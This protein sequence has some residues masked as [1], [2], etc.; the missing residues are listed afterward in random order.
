MKFYSVWLI[1]LTMLLATANASAA[2]VNFNGGAVSTCTLSGNTYSC[3]GMPLGDN[4]IAVIASGYTVVLSSGF[5][6]GWA[7]GLSMSGSAALQTTSGNPI[8]LT[9]SNNISVSGGTLTAGGTFTLGSNP[10]TITANVFAAAVST[11]GSAA[12]I[13]GNVTAGSADFGSH[14]T[15]SG[16]VNVGTISTNADVSMGSLTATGSISLGSKNTVTGAVIGASISTNSQ[17]TMGSLT[18]SG[19]ADLASQN[20]VNGPVSANVLT[21]NSNVTLNGDINATSSF[22][23][24][25]GS[26]LTGNV[27]SPTV[28]LNPSNVTVQGNI[29]ASNTLDIGSG[30][31]VTGKVTGGS[32]LMRPANATINGSVT[33]SGDVD[34][35]SQSA[36]NGD[37][38]ARDVLTRS[39]FANINGNAA[40][41]SIYIDWHDAVSGV[42]TC[43]G[44][45]AA[46]CSCVTKADPNY[47]PTCGAAPP[48]VPHHFQINHGGTGLTCQPQ[49]VTVIACANAACSAPYFTSNVDVT[50]QPGGQTFTISGGINSA[51]TVSAS[52]AKT[53]TLSASASGV[54][55]ATTCVNSGSGAPCDMVFS[56]T[57]L[58]VSAPNHVSMTS[59][60]LV[61]LQALTSSPGAPSCIPLVSNQT[62]NIDMACSFK[63]PA[64]GT[65]QVGIG[66]KSASC[67]PDAFGSTVSVP[68]TFD[69]NG[70]ATAP[71]QYA[72]VGKVALNATYTTARFSATGSG[73]FIAAPARF[74]VKATSATASIGPAAAVPAP[75]GKF[76]KASEPFT[77][78]VTALNA[79]NGTTPNFGKENPASK[80]KFTPSVNNP[81]EVPTLPA[82]TGNHGTLTYSAPSF[83]GG[84]GNATASFDDVGYLKLTAALDDGTSANA[85][86]LGQPLASFQTSGTQFVSRF[87]PDHFDTEL[88][89]NADTIPVNF[90]TMA[91]PN[92]SV[93]P[94][95]A[96]SSFTHSRQNFL[97]LVKAYNGAATPALTTN[98]AGALAQ[99]IDLS[100]ATANGGS[101]V[102]NKGTFSWSAESSA[103]A[104][105]PP[106]FT[107]S[108]GVGTLSTTGS[109]YNLPAFVLSSTPS[110]PVTLYLRATEQAADGA[111]SQ[112]STASLSM[113]APLTVVDGR[114]FVTNG[115]GSPNAALPVKVNAQ[116]YMP[117]GYVF[118]ALAEAVGSG[119]LSKYIKFS[120]CQKSLNAGGGSCPLSIK[121]S[122]ASAGLI[123]IITKGLAKDNFKLAAPGVSSIGSVDVQLIN[124]SGINLI[125]FLP[126]TTGRET[127]G[128]YRS[129]PVIY[130]R[131]VF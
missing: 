103:S 25:S 10:Q 110:L 85:Y 105:P 88:V 73:D 80:V 65:I 91:C 72:D 78:T 116:Y 87:V 33:L 29:N 31:T 122:D 21:T 6:P 49:T 106:R 11:G 34:M 37:L 48:G 59:G 113:E 51:A 94:C 129:G 125:P 62:V 41:N 42:I 86:Y 32:L 118:N 112:R 53:Y 70:L 39:S 92:S 81:T 123:I 57:G 98:Y 54:G 38:V 99:V 76:A 8:N 52:V 23:L 75:S 84:V 12:T 66:A 4:D 96:G 119:E 27:T 19:T 35:G 71:L 61:T 18:V 131:E 97:M 74:Q 24:G 121:L 58:T 68:F 82:G 107:F 90:H 79:S 63:N 108:G 95:V 89:P 69:G 130:T 67:G 5:S 26:A 104:S 45:G 1:V 127:F 20:V 114:L 22:T 56:G 64:S 120:N 60:A 13:N 43:T 101:V 17:V 55:N 16:S 36:I 128:V 15:I 3:P 109:S 111:S 40:V 124:D 7:Q 117:S 44:P 46:G 50:L 77:L 115:Y 9:G 126:S 30:N 14:T 47:Q 2:N 100:A 93:N 28:T 102:S 83:S